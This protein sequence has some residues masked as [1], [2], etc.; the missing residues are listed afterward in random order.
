MTPE[1]L[2]ALAR[3]VSMRF[4]DAQLSTVV[5]LARYLRRDLDADDWAVRRGLDVMALRRD[6]EAI[7]RVLRSETQVGVAEVLQESY[8]VSGKEAAR[9]L[10][11][12]GVTR[13]LVEG[14]VAE[15][16]SGRALA[17]LT[18]DLTTRLA[19]TERRILR[20]TED[21]YSQ[22]VAKA[23]TEGLLGRMTRRQVAQAAL[24][25]FADRGITGFVTTDGRRMNLASYTEMAT[26]TAALNASR[27]GKLDA[28]RA[29][30]HDLAIV[31]S[32]GS[33]CDSCAPWEGEVISI[34]GAT[35]G[36][37]TYDEAAGS[38]HLFGPNCGHQADPYI[39]GLTE[40]QTP[41]RS[42]PERYAALQQQR[43]L[44]RGVRQYKMR[45]AAALDD[46]AAA[47]AQ[48][49]VREWQGRLRAHVSKNDLPRLYYRE[50]V[51]K[52]I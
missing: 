49:K 44:E 41:M 30:G 20:A 1:Q 7:V 38:G 22:V 35:P 36:Y 31:S 12:A 25:A 23:T 33:G 37:P 8:S 28:M 32:N 13:A 4:D 5:L 14:P 21:A 15:N 50:Q 9:M 6:V 52:A 26:R 42:D 27:V 10:A 43:Y 48:A 17:A 40:E 19:G 51:G 39:P 2:Q 46:Q 34:D 11:A 24:N 29:R 47:A 16:A 18:V 3:R 45:G